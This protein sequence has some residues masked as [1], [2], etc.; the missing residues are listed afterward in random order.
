MTIALSDEHVALGH[1]GAR[2]ARVPLPAECAEG[3]A[4]CRGRGSPADLE[5]DGRRGMAGDPSSRGVRG[6]GFRALRTGCCARGDRAVDGAGPAPAH[7]GH[8]RPGLR[9]GRSG[10]AGPVPARPD[11]RR[12]RRPPSRWESRLWPWST[13]AAPGRSPF[14]APSG[15]CWVPRRHRW[16]WLRL[17]KMAA[18]RSG[19]CWRCPN[20]TI[21]CP[22][23]PCPASIPPAGWGRSTWTRSRSPPSNSSAPSPP[24]GC[25]R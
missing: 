9:I 4:R 23:A 6:S 18:G 2:V 16:C 10:S 12:P 13:G 7:G 11:R 15:R 17:E 14:R 3:A 22:L 20:R 19:A 8:L 5:G 1:V 24:I 25:V 21:G